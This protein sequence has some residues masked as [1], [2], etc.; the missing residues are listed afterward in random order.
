[1]LRSP[2]G[3]SAFREWA[4]IPCPLAVISDDRIVRVR[5]SAATHMFDLIHGSPGT[6]QGVSVAYQ[7]ILGWLADVPSFS[8]GFPFRSGPMMHPVDYERRFRTILLHL[9]IQHMVPVRH[10]AG[11][12]SRH[13][14]AQR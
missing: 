14:D 2:W 12:L 1:M 9:P 11:G 3:S 7:V 8:L 13:G 4:S 6:D 10:V 5:S